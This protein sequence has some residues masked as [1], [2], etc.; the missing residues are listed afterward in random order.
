MANYLLA[1]LQCRFLLHWASHFSIFAFLPK[2]FSNSIVNSKTGAANPETVFNF[3]H[4][5]RGVNKIFIDTK[6]YQLQIIIFLCDYFG[7]F[8]SN[9][10]VKVYQ[11]FWGEFLNDYFEVRG[12]LLD[13]MEQWLEFI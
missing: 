8:S 7:A 12:F 1:T 9:I 2:I 4:L 10:N 11:D 6:C 13:N 3:S 5:I